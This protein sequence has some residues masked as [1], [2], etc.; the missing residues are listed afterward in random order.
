MLKST[1]SIRLCDFFLKIM[2]ARQLRTRMAANYPTWYQLLY[3]ERRR[4]LEIGLFYFMP[5]LG[6]GIDKRIGQ[7]K[8]RRV[9]DKQG[10]LKFI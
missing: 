7:K 1:G 10:H 2:D 6:S 8:K 5:T 9:V 4:P 3:L